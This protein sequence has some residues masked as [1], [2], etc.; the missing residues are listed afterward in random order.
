MT[1][2]EPS[3]P[4]A[5]S[6]SST[7]DIV[8]H[9]YGVVPAPVTPTEEVTPL[10]ER[11]DSLR[12]EAMAWIPFLQKK[13]FEKEVPLLTNPAEETVEPWLDKAERF[14]KKHAVPPKLRPFLI[15]QRTKNEAKASWLEVLQGGSANAELLWSSAKYLFA[16]KHTQKERWE[17]SSLLSGS[18]IRSNIE[19]VPSRVRCCCKCCV[20]CWSLSCCVL[21]GCL[22]WCCCE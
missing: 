22:K 13:D 21:V 7:P 19:L 5:S 6:A 20:R 10:R 14:F 17:L 16:E 15:E 18:S 9:D 1:R 2:S 3:R 4:G 8:R 12:K 11:F